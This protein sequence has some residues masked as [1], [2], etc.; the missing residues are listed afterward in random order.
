MAW[1]YLQ[2]SGRESKAVSLKASAYVCK[3]VGTISS[4]PFGFEFLANT[5]ARHPD[6]MLEAWTK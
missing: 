2:R 1:F 4:K 5:S 3:D 6:T